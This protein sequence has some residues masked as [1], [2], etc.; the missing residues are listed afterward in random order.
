VESVDTI[1]PGTVITSGNWRDYTKFMPDGMVSL[2]AGKFF[3]Q[4]PADL[5][6]EIEPTTIDSLPKNYLATTE[7]YAAQNK[8]V[9]LP[10]GGLNL[11]GYHG[12]IPFPNTQ[13]P[14]KGWKLLLN[15]WYRYAPHLIVDTDGIGCAI[16]SFG[17][18]NCEKFEIVARQL[19]YVTDAGIPEAPP[20]PNAKFLAEWFMVTEPE[21]EKYT[22]SLNLDY[23]DLTQPEDAYVFLPSLRRYQRVSVSARCS[24][25]D[26]TD[27]TSEDFRSGLDSNL[28]ELQA[29][30]L[31]HRKILAM[32]DPR[33]LLKPFPFGFALPLAWPTPELGKWQLRDV[34]VISVKKIPARAAG[35]CYGNRIIY[36][37][38]HFYSPL[39]EELYDAQM[40]LWKFDMVMPQRMNIPGVGIANLPGADVEELWDVKRNHATVGAEGRPTLYLNEQAPV[41]FQDISRYT[42]PA[43]LNLIMR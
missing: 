14:H 7:K 31:G 43:G 15:L 27:W 5:R 21:Q 18:Q 19:S 11:V 10:D 26:G 30:Y 20:A 3:W 36:M 42:T 1:A 13:E 39:W 16:D 38:S 22:A 8:I 12:G 35:Y 40:K 33:P 2:L 25:F 17:S 28:T 32:V 4:A 29:D 23:T 34:E 24:A 9:E 37:D 6:M 41:E